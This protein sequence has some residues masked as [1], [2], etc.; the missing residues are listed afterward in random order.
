MWMM[1]APQE[2]AKPPSPRINSTRTG[3]KVLPE[4]MANGVD[5]YGHHCSQDNVNIDRLVEKDTSVIECRDDSS[6]ETQSRGIIHH[7]L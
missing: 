2:R 7:T 1:E 3:N 5:L 4:S 6:K